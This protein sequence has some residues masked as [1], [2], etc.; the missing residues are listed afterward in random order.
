M[1]K[2]VKNDQ[3]V[4]VADITKENG[5]LSL[6]QNNNDAIELTREDAFKLV[7]FIINRFED[8]ITENQI[9]D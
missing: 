5:F 9:V 2:I 8:I 1:L 3:E 7:K 4:L 6:S